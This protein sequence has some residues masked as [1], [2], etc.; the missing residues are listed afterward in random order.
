M[1]GLWDLSLHE[2]ALRSTVGASLGPSVIGL[3]VLAGGLSLK[4]DLACTAAMAGAMLALF[5]F[6]LTGHTSIHPDRWVLAPLL[7]IHLVIVAFWFG[8]LPA[9]Y[10]ASK[11]ESAV[12]LV[13][14]LDTFSVVA[15]ALVPLIFLVGVAMAVILMASMAILRQPYGE[16]LIAKMTSFAVLMGLASLNKWRLVPAIKNGGLSMLSALRRSVATEYLFIFG[17]ITATAAM[18]ALF[19]PE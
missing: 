2:T 1:S 11:R 8:A 17:L 18:T 6:L 3:L 5:A 16:F 9:L 14:L 7:A 15:T 12:V 13:K 19:S 10:I 4:D